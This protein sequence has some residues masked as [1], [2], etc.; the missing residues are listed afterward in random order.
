M[1]RVRNEKVRREAEIEKELA[2]KRDDG[3]RTG[4]KT[5]ES[6]FE[7]CEWLD[8]ETAMLP[9]FERAFETVLLHSII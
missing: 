5:V 3:E 2:S 6:P 7:I 4:W 9:W 8:Y 1:D